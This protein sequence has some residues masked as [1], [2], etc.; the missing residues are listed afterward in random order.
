MSFY[1]AVS[2]FINAVTSVILAISV[3]R[4]HKN[5]PVGLSFIYFALSIALWSLFYFF[6]QLSESEAEA[7]L[8]ARLLI[9]AAVFVPVSFF[10]LSAALK[11]QQY[12]WHIRIGTLI[13]V[14]FAIISLSTSWIVAGVSPK[15]G[16]P[17]WPDAGGGL[18]LYLLFW[19]Y[20]VVGSIVVLA[21][22][23][24]N[25]HE[26]KKNQLKY[27]LLGCGIGFFGGS[28]NF[29]LWYDI[30]IPPVGNLLVSFY[31]FGVGYA[32]ARY[33]LMDVDVALLKGAA[34]LSVAVLLA[35][36]YPVTWALIDLRASREIQGELFAAQYF[37]S[38]LLIGFVFVVAPRLK[39]ALNRFVETR[40][41]RSQFGYRTE[42]RHLI[43]RMYHI[44]RREQ[45][46]S[47]VASFLSEKLV[48]D[49]VAVFLRETAGMSF[50]VRARAGG[51]DFGNKPLEEQGPVVRMMQK[52]SGVICVEEVRQRFS[53]GKSG[54]S[55]VES[56]VG[57]LTRLGVE[58]AIPF[59]TEERLH[60][61]ILLGRR[62]P[63][64]YY[65]EADLALLEGLGI[66]IAAT[67]RVRELE[68]RS[69]E[70]EKLMALGTMAAGLAHELRNPMVSVQTYI[71]M[72]E[73]GDAFEGLG[74]NSNMLGIVQRDLRRMNEIVQNVGAFARSVPL[75]L[76]PVDIK[77]VID[78]AIEIEAENIKKNRVEVTVKSEMA[79]RVHGDFNQLVQVFQNL[80]VN[81]VQA[82]QAE[83]PR[84]I[85]VT[86]V[87]KSDSRG[88]LMASVAVEDTGPGID[89]DIIRSIF[90]PFVT[91]KATGSVVEHRGMGLGLAI[92]KQLVESHNGVVEAFNRPNGGSLFR[93]LLPLQQ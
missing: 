84:R 92:V 67:I 18:W 64:N 4:Y 83:S 34:Y 65:S 47:E 51:G 79:H 33:R 43:R 49:A 22:D 58:V 63:R 23:F 15:M 89:L 12:K 61:F 24:K 3:Y 5:S 59:W 57:E 46:F 41:E 40:L 52:V 62:S 8:F 19:F 21:R 80:L 87:E 71:S 93:L 16:V 39:S 69:A 82:F 68:R 78:A 29:F 54:D 70:N 44:E 88:R 32:I 20:L 90:E 53:A 35:V 7:I 76:K 50:T 17:Y 75:E 55:V 28:T 31:V 25:Q 74:S 81:S 2:A 72:L 26:T 13:A 73:D 36:L 30:P 14:V 42:L 48:I 38:L 66:E 77:E 37:V 45:I 9:A 86:A 1:C 27:V 56:G 10:H 11:A 6:W 91:T 60:G 85:M